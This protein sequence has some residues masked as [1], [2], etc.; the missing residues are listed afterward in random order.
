MKSNYK[1]IGDYIRLVDNRNIGLKVTTLLGL[2][3]NKEFIPSVANTI[4][5]DMA[6][7]KIIRKNQ[8][9]CSLMQVRRDKKIPVALLKDFDEAMI[10]QAYPVFE[11]IDT[12]KLLPEY[13]M[14]W[15]SRSEFD[16]EACFYAVGGVRGSLEW[17]DFCNMELSVPDIE[18]QKAIAKEYNTIVNRIK[19]NEQ[20]NQKL[21]ETAQAI[22]KQWFV[23]F[24][25]PC[26][27]QD[28]SPA[29]YVR[30]G[31]PSEQV[32]LGLSVREAKA[33]LNKVCIYKRVG[34][35][36]V[37]D[38]KSWF[39]Y[40][41]L[42]MPSSKDGHIN[43]GEVSF[44]KGI[45][46][47]LYR[48]FYEHFIGQGA[49]WTKEHKPIK[50]IHYEKF[51]SQEEAAK[52]EKELKTGYG[53][54]WLQRQYSKINIG[55]PAPKDGIGSPAP[56]CQ[57][58]KAGEMVLNEDLGKEIPVGWKVVPLGSICSKIGSGSTPKGGKAG[59]QDSGK[60]FVRSLNV[61][62]YNFS[63][64]DLAFINDSQAK[65]LENVKLEK[66]DV[67]L[68]ITG[69]SVARCS[70]VP[71]SIL[72]AH[73]NQH[74][75]IVRLSSKVAT[76]HYLLCALCSTDYKSR[77]LG[78]SEGGSTRQALTKTDIEECEL[79]LPDLQVRTKF[80]KTANCIFKLKEVLTL[81]KRLLGNVLELLLASIVSKD[82]NKAS[83]R[84]LIC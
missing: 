12:Q 21:E 27:P 48:R 39:V 6:N 58:R 33:E 15:F 14:M 61:F 13:L 84:P 10:S 81:E 57:L 42:C 53:R 51:D 52:R 11:I 40:V 65:K 70:I 16:R 29:H 60:A 55:L 71:Q 20:F 17:E 38:G 77:L 76:P 18:K 4:G 62:D 32:N 75:S 66:C 35:L 9:A 28:Y 25:F 19:L 31:S 2:T 67:L 43:D 5:T 68:N 63:Y 34:G 74:V 64:K 79:L 3:I 22:Y 49:D 46:N 72:P 45:T 59:Y 82:A 69:V 44:Y 8:F 83:V 80:E 30:A 24:E 36:P 73:V 7:Y 41:L 26:L 47:D 37:P 1:K 56:E 78:I 54:T 23:D 50:V